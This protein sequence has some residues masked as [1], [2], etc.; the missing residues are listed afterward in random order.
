MP[1]PERAKH[2]ITRNLRGGENTDI[3]VLVGFDGIIRNSNLVQSMAR[4]SAA[5]LATR[6]LD[7]HGTAIA[8]A[9]AG[10]TYGVANHANIVSVKVWGGRSTIRFSN[11]IAGLQWVKDKVKATGRPSVVLLAVGGYHSPALNRNID[12]V[13]RSGTPVVVS[14]T[15]LLKRPDEPANSPASARLPVVVGSTDIT[16]H[17]TKESNY[18]PRVDLFA[19]GQNI[20]TAGIADDNAALTCTGTSMAAAAVAG[21]IALIQGP[22]TNAGAIRSTDILLRWVVEGVLSGMPEH[23]KEY[24]QN[25][26]AHIVPEND[27]GDDMADPG[28]VQ[29]QA[30]I[31]FGIAAWDDISTWSSPTTD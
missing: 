26:L 28:S 8:A 25:R 11:I 19:P 29:I 12:S 9:A 23:W 18:G 15:T 7:G 20:P 14:S 16:D 3:Y 13:V 4:I 24:T 27:K 31:S 6:T 5:F 22:P 21:I 30:T 10:E 1:E 2:A 17:I